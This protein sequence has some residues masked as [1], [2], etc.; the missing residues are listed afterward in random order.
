MLDYINY[1]C[2][3]NIDLGSADILRDKLEYLLFKDW[4][5]IIREKAELIVG[6][7]RV[8]ALKEYLRCSKSLENK[9]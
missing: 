3:Y 2:A 5:T 8:E 7:Y 1:R 4:D 6:N 9:G